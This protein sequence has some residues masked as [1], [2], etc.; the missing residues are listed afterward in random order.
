MSRSWRQY[1]N[2]SS[3]ETSAQPRRCAGGLHHPLALHDAFAVLLVAALRQM[4]LEDRGSRLLDLEEQR[5][6]VVTTLEQGD[7][8][9][10]ADAPDPDDLAGH[11]DDLELLQQMA[12]V[13]L[14]R[15]A[16]GTELFEDRVL[17]LVGGHP[18]G[19]PE[20]SGRDDDRWLARR[21][22][23]CRPRALRAWTAPAGCR[24]CGP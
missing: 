9:P 14:Q 16:V 8:R 17:K 23:T 5:V 21:S 6:L 11:I 4:V 19:W 7:E 20:V 1:R 24:A 3:G 15:R 22:G 13:V 2:R 18:V 10:R 12:A